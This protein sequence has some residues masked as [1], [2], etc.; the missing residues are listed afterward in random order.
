MLA[1]HLG[2]LEA[3]DFRHADVHQHDGDIGFQKVL[4]GFPAGI[5]FDQILAQFVEDGFVAEQLGRLIIHHQDVD[6]VLRAH[7][8]PFLSHCVSRLNA[9]TGSP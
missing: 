6:L 9:P 3:V 8:I 4:E 7:G 5:G 1:D 2:E